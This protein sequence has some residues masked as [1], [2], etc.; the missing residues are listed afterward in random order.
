M[1]RLDNI[2]E[3]HITIARLE[4]EMS[5]QNHVFVLDTNKQALSP[6]HPARA[7]ELLTKGK[8]AVYQ[9]YPFT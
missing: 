3:G 8:A 2:V 4:T 6:C 1:R 9:M 7:R 5:T